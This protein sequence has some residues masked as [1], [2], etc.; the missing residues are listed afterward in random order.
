MNH[1]HF[2]HPLMDFLSGVVVPDDEVDQSIEEYLVVSKDASFHRK[3][4]SN[5]FYQKR[6][7]AVFGIGLVLQAMAE[8]LQRQEDFNLASQYLLG[9]NY[10]KVPMEP[11][12][13]DGLLFL[14]DNNI[15]PRSE[16][17]MEQYMQR[18]SLVKTRLKAVK[19]A[20]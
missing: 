17:L 14:L 10:K 6:L 2:K 18:V 7:R 4:A 5:P 11:F 1:T 8:L 9:F 12:F 20:S 3:N 16:T 13:L 19:F 15:N